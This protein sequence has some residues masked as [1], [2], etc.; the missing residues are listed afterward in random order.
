MFEQSLVPPTIKLGLQHPTLRTT[1]IL[2]GRVNNRGA[3][4]TGKQKDNHP[5]PPRPSGVSQATALAA[6]QRDVN[7][8]LSIIGA[9]SASKRLTDI[10]GSPRALKKSKQG[11]G[12]DIDIGG[13]S[14]LSR[15]GSSTPNGSH[16]QENP[17]QER[18]AATRIRLSSERDEIDK[19]PEGGFS[20]LGAAKAQRSVETTPLPMASL[21]DRIKDT[22]S[23][24]DLVRRRKKR[25]GRRRFV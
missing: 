20:I 4:S 2:P 17:L 9:H 18:G 16:A 7:S 13:P 21:L 6:R 8:T 10:D 1:D 14:L 12:G 23:E 25:G 19:R 11:D 15:M 24:D 22:S 5:L 3:E